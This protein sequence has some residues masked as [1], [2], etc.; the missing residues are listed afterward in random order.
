MKALYTI[1]ALLII[2]TTASARDVFPDR[3]P[4]DLRVLE[5]REGIAVIQDKKGNKEEV[6]VGDHLGKDRRAIM[7]IKNGALIVGDDGGHSRVPFH[8]GVVQE[9][10][11][12]N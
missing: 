7:A 3:N 11:D 6:A 12:P 8:T 5:T 9:V 2:A 10:R 1:F 4:G